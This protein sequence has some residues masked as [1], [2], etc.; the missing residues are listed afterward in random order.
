[1]LNFLSEDKT[2]DKA[3]EILNLQDSQ[4]AIANVGQLT[5]FN[6]LDDYYWGGSRQT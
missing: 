1:M 4:D 2:R 6:Q 3:R 5:T